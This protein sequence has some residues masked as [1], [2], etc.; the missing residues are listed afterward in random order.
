MEKHVLS[1]EGG[2]GIQIEEPGLQVDI[3]RMQP[4]EAEGVTGLVYEAFL[5]TYHKKYLYRP[6]QIRKKLESGE[7]LPVVA[8]SDDGQV[9]GYASLGSY[10]GYPEIGLIGSLIVS[11]RFRGKG[12]GAGIVQHLMG[13]CEGEGYASIAGGAFTIHPYSQRLLQRQGMETCAVLLGS[14]PEGLSFQGIAENTAG[15]ESMAYLAKPVSC[16]T[17]GQQYLPE[18]HRAILEEIGNGLGIRFEPGEV[19]QPQYEP[20]V[21]GNLLNTETG[22]GY[23][24]V[25]NAGTSCRRILDGIISTLRF[26]GAQV[27]RMHIDLSD[28]GCPEAVRNAEEKGFVFSG[29]IPGKNGGILLMQDIRGVPLVPDQIQV[30]GPLGEKILAYVQGEMERSRTHRN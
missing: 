27:I 19:S 16:T 2:H 7:I 11:P 28:P 4:A 26:Q 15:R 24:W 10:P 1:K 22:A 17:Y 5:D 18:Q 13:C 29:M 8:T 9:I 30:T 25:R 6:T 12:L 21:I 23:I 20:T 14:M 3:H